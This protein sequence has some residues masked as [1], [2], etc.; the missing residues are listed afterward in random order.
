MPASTRTS[1]GT[2]RRSA[3]NTAS[4]AASGTTTATS[5]HPTGTELLPTSSTPMA[6]VAAA[7]AAYKPSVETRRGV[8]VSGAALT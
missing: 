5:D 7:I 4:Q 1:T 2:P 3:L 8:S 6:A